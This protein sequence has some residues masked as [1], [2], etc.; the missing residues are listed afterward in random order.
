MYYLARI[1]LG[2]TLQF[3]SAGTIVPLASPL[4]SGSKRQEGSLILERAQFLLRVPLGSG[5]IKRLR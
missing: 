1:Y 3:K 5:P 4:R 2:K